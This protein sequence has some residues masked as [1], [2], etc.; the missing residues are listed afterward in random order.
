M[1]CNSSLFIWDSEKYL[2]WMTIFHDCIMSFAGTGV[3]QSSQSVRDIADR[4]D[5]E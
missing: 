5:G 4:H 2:D 1:S 3:S